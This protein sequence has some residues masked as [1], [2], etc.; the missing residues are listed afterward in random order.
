MEI[1]DNNL[2]F[3]IELL[4]ISEDEK[5]CEQGLYFKNKLKNCE[6][7]YIKKGDHKKYSDGKISKLSMNNSSLCISCKCNNYE[8]NETIINMINIYDELKDYFNK[9]DCYIH[10]MINIFYDEDYPLSLEFGEEL[11]ELLIKHH[12]SLPIDCYSKK[13]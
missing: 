3:L 13:K 10:F 7:E 6:T 12:F 8:Y 2:D 9:I 4:F 1:I 5:L 11:M